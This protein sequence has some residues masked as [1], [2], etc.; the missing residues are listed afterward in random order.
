MCFSLF[1]RKQ[2][3]KAQTF[4][5]SLNVFLWTVSILPGTDKHISSCWTVLH[6]ITSQIQ[7]DN[8]PP[9]SSFPEAFTDVKIKAC[10]ILASGRCS[11]PKVDE[12]YVPLTV[13]TQAIYFPV[14]F[15]F[16]SPAF[17]IKKY[18]NLSCFYIY[19]EICVSRQC[20]QSCFGNTAVPA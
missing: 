5:N 8:K 16:K 4:C 6:R 7:L 12:A 2:R 17:R 3:K 1:S 13:Q 10:K 11:I 20:C 9:Y 14:Y 18:Q 15:P 19:T